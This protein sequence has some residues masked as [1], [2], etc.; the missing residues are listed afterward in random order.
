MNEKA[1]D[2]R[3]G[4]I[5]RGIRHDLRA[6]FAQLLVA[7]RVDGIEICCFLGGIETKE[8]AYGAGEEKSNGDDGRAD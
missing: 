3:A 4:A 1:M 5:T 2:A 6:G 7:Q 8:D